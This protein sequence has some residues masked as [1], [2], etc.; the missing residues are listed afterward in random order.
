ME[1][2]VSIIMPNYNGGVYISDTIESVINQTYSNFEFII[3]DDAS[4]DASREIISSFKDERIRLISKEKNEH[5][6]RALNMGIEYA[7]GS[8]I[9]RVDSDDKWRND[10]LKRQIEYLENHTECGACFT[11]ADIIDDKGN[12]V[13][14]D[15]NLLYSLF[16]QENKTREEWIR[17]L[18]FEGNCLCHPSAVI[19]ADMVR[20]LDGYRDSL[21]QL[22]DYDMWLRLLKYTNI[23]VLEEELTCYRR[24]EDNNTSI[25]AKGDDNDTRCYNEKSYI[26]NSYLED[27]DDDLFVSCFR[28]DFVNKAS[29]TKS[30]L[31]CEKAFL[32]YRAGM[33]NAGREVAVRKLEALIDCNNYRNVLQE[34]F[35][36]NC[37]DFYRLNK[38]HYYF[39]YIIRDNNDKVLMAEAAVY[40]KTQSMQD[41]AM[42]SQ[43]VQIKNGVLSVSFDIPS[44]AAVVRF[45]PVDNRSCIIAGIKAISG[46]KELQC[47]PV[48]GQVSDGVWLFSTRDPQIIIIV[49]CGFDGKLR[50][51]ADIFTSNSDVFINSVGALEN[52][53]LENRVCYEKDKIR[54]AEL[55]SS[56][57]NYRDMIAAKDNHIYNLDNIIAAKAAEI[58]SKEQYIQR[59]ENT[60]SAMENT[61][62]WKLYRKIRKCW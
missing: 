40:Y 47:R 14:D 41:F 52:T 51:E 17:K 3:V 23:Y 34:R 7:K 28:D 56:V 31:T 26:L 58:D 46:D 13:S 50:I 45:D 18:L 55:E 62:I 35:N 49:P 42:V 21:L 19:R 10:K 8:Y 24:I 32:L 44:D 20:R 53:L 5:I 39:D 6:C 57:E 54:I 15:N 37:R 59:L 43:R 27:M 29:K 36:F 16:R 60:I 33:N 4:T 1:P 2:L 38:E 25:S 12:S 48:N 30:E 11:W 9:A 61:K 22:Q